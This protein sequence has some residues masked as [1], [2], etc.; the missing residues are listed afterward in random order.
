MPLTG[1]TGNPQ[2]IW[3]STV[4][5]Y[6]TYMAGFTS[7]TGVAGNIFEIT[8]SASTTV[9]VLRIV[10]QLGGSD[11][12]T[13]KKQSAADSGGTVAVPASVPLNSANS[14]ATAGLKLYT[15]APTTP[16][17]LV[18]NI[19]QIT[20]TSLDMNFHGNNTIPVGP[21]QP[22]ILSGEAQTLAVNLTTGATVTGFVQWV[23]I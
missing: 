4:A 17:T 13:V 14:A 5:Q 16:G 21:V 20:G 10:L 19:L 6:S 23:E 8:G 9:Y 22:V 7:F 15:V 1:T 3:E 12:I 2:P 18:G 11:T